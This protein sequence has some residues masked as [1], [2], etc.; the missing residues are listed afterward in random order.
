[1]E[2]VSHLR[3]QLAH[4]DAPILGV[5]VNA[6]KAEGGAYGIGY[7]YAYEPSE[8]DVSRLAGNGMTDVP[9]PRERAGR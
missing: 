3:Q 7:G 2:S 1:M 4:L 9:D 8:P 6:F 5:V